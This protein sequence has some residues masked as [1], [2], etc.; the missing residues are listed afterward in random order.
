MCKPEF[1]LKLTHSFGQVNIYI[2]NDLFQHITQP[3]IT[4]WSSKYHNQLL[5]HGQANIIMKQ[6]TLP[7][8]HENRTVSK[9]IEMCIKV[10]CNP[11]FKTE[12]LEYK[13]RKNEDTNNRKKNN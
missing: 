11:N 13:I 3:V 8:H 4:T 12:T 10:Q 2:N 6:F 1:V 5:L 7:T 9:I